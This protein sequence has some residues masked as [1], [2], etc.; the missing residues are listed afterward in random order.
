MSRFTSTAPGHGAR[1]LF[2]YC[3]AMSSR[4]RNPRESAGCSVRIITVVLPYVLHVLLAVGKCL[5]AVEV[6]ADVQTDQLDGPTSMMF[7]KVPK[8]GSTTLASILQL[9]ANRGNFSYFN[10]DMIRSCTHMEQKMHAAA[11]SGKGFSPAAPLFVSSHMPFCKFNKTFVMT[12]AREPVSRYVS[13]YYYALYGSRPRKKLAIAIATARKFANLTSRDP[14]VNDMIEATKIVYGSRCLQHEEGPFPTLNN[15][16]V[17]Y[18]CGFNQDHPD[19]KDICSEAALQRAIHNIRHGFDF[20]GM[21]D[22][23]RDSLEILLLKMSPQWYADFG[24][25]VTA[26]VG[27]ILADA[28][29]GHRNSNE[30]KHELEPP[31]E[32]TKATL[33]IFNSNDMKL[34]EAISDYYAE[35]ALE[36]GFG[37]TGD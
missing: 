24:S 36:Y 4:K 10:N 30:K 32:D 1:N 13:H 34:F 29:I 28:A 3:N 27:S 26:V 7:V 15:Q 2:K 25:N 20:V 18:F 31:T 14:D 23:F 9:M 35:V 22:R 37:T 11:K 21:M 8:T 33:R 5:D 6:H 12:M 17:Y 19:C 16:H